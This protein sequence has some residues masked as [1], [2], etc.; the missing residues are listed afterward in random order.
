MTEQISDSFCFFSIYLGS[1]VGALGLSLFLGKSLVHILYV[2]S[3]LSRYLMHIFS[4]CS[5]ANLNISSF[6]GLML[7]SL[8]HSVYRTTVFCA[9]QRWEEVSCRI[10]VD[11]PSEHPIPN[12][13]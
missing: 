10:L 12:K 2:L 8:T 7:C 9:N 6:L 5:M 13:R 1:V 4:R 3:S 11:V